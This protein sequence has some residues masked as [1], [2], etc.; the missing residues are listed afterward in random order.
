VATPGEAWIRGTR[1]C[2]GTTYRKSRELASHVTAPAAIIPSRAWSV[3]RNEHVESSIACPG[4]GVAASGRHHD[5]D[6]TIGSR[7]ST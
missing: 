2:G 1:P 3:Y 6:L 7:P 4:D 5:R